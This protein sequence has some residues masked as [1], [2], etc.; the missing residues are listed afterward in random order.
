MA[1]QYAGVAGLPYT[2]IRIR[3]GDS[4]NVSAYHTGTGFFYAS[5]TEKGTVGL[6]VSN[7]HVISNKTWIELDF[8]L[9]DSNNNRIFGP[10]KTIRIPHGAIP[11]I[12][13]PDKNVD[14]AALPLAPIE[15]QFE[16]S[17]VRPHVVYLTKDIIISPSV[18]EVLQVATS[19]LMVGFPNG[20]MDEANNFPVV[21]RGILARAVA[22]QSGSYPAA[23]K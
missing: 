12:E 21:R 8:G 16:I 19:V 13:H 5:Q 1:D 11:I 22:D 18:E 2:V 4:V 10:P 15:H 6:I 7:K 20:I 3:A 17:G 23:A 9:K 14:L